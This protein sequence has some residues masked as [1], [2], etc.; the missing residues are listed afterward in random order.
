M[1]YNIKYLVIGLN[2]SE[3]NYMSLNIIMISFI[4]P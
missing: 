1:L 3:T 2:I 4:S